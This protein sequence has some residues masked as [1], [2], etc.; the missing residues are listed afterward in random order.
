MHWTLEL[1][2]LTLQIL[3]AWRTDQRAS[4]TAVRWFLRT[5]RATHSAKATSSG[6]LSNPYYAVPNYRMWTFTHC[7]T[8]P[9]RFSSRRVLIHTHRAAQRARRHAHGPRPLWSYVRRRAPASR[10]DDGPCFRRP[11][12]WSSNGRQKNRVASRRTDAASKKANEI[13][14]FLGGDGGT[15]TPDPLHAK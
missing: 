6:A 12:D 1:P 4:S 10:R 2:E 7:A 13:S 3:E 9:T 5:P 11:R 8:R 15:R 14:A